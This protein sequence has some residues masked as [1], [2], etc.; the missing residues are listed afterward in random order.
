M[1]WSFLNPIVKPDIAGLLAMKRYDLLDCSRGIAAILIVAY[2][3]RLGKY[4]PWYW[5]AMD[6]FFVMSG[7]LITRTLVFIAQ[8]ENP[9]R[10]FFVYRVARLMPAMLLLCGG[11]AVFSAV[12]DTGRS[13]SAVLPYVLL[14]QN[15]D[16]LFVG[17]AVLPRVDMLRHIWSLVLE[18]HFYVL[19][20]LFAI[21]W[22][23]R[24]P[25][26]FRGL[27][28]VSL[29]TMLSALWFR[30]EG[31]HWWTLPGRMDGF[32][33]GS[34]MGLL[35]F[36]HNVSMPNPQLLRKYVIGYFVVL[37]LAILWLLHSA[38]LSYSNHALYQTGVTHWLDV[39][40]YA[41]LSSFLVWVLMA[42][43]KVA[44]P[45]GW[46]R[47]FSRFFGKLSYELYLFHVPVL[48]FWKAVMDFRGSGSSLLLFAL[49]MAL[50][51]LLAYL[52]NRFLTEPA[53]RNRERWV[54]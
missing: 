8:K 36:S 23:V 45:G 26:H 1:K 35:L 7:V 40:C 39:S 37:T 33:I 17:E 53:L 13:P 15:L 38:W 49:V 5:G 32:L 29:A 10:R 14:Y 31:G 18:E 51:T 34:V 54:K 50:S 11:Y 41:I 48:F 28:I 20:G 44:G 25:L 21:Y 6:F 12:I 42:Y 2:H 27:V 47:K 4:F 52:T 16:Y 46:I 22:G 30:Y 9:V 19:W 24:R 43:E 3:C